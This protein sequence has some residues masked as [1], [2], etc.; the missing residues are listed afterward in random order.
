LPINYTILELTTYLEE[1][2]GNKKY[3][4][5]GSGIPNTRLM[6]VL[7]D[8][9]SRTNESDP[10]IFIIFL[11]SLPTT[12]TTSKLASDLEEALGNK[13]YHHQDRGIPNTRLM[14]VPLDHG[15]RTTA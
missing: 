12:Y 1:A 5:L 8:H 15:A 7:L 3:H 14:S 11:E 6:S 13:K 9:C 2:L 10:S 4:H